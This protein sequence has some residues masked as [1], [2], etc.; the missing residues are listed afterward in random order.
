MPDVYHI[1]IKVRGGCVC[2]CV[3][4]VEKGIKKESD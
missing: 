3:K 1:L 4:V 2:M